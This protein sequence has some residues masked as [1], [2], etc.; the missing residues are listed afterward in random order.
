M[1]LADS[2]VWIDYLN[3]GDALFNRV[4]VEQLVLLHP[5]VIG[6]L[7]LGSMKSRKAQL[8]YLKLLPQAD[9]ATDTEVIALIENSALYC[10]GI[11]YIDAH[12][13][14]SAK[15]SGVDFWTRDKRLHQAA[16][17]LGLTRLH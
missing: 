5:F 8:R 9:E 14:A 16:V 6:E 4:L 15:I 13:L 11:G 7:A 2:S 10:T 17:R 12:L 1:I 3:K